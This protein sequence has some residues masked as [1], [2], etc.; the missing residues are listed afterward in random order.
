MVEHTPS[1]WYH[2]LMI[3]QLFLLLGHA[4]P[5]RIDAIACYVLGASHV[6][7][8]VFK[9]WWERRWRGRP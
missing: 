7:L 9:L 6:A 3:G 8:A 4:A 1:R 2:A 5:S